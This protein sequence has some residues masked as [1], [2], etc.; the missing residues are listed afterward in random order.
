[1][2]ALRDRLRRAAVTTLMVSHGT[3]M[4]LMGDEVGRSQRGNN[5]AY[6]QDNEISWLDWSTPRDPH[7]TD[8]LRGLVMIRKSRPLL[9]PAKF[10]HGH[11]AGEAG[12]PDVVWLKPDGGRMGGADWGNGA[13]GELG[14]MLSG[15]GERSLLLLFNPAAEEIAFRLPDRGEPVRW[16]ALVDSA[17]AEI[18]PEREAIAAGET[19]P[20]PP[21]AVLVLE[22]L[23]VLK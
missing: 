11:P 17:A 7:F 22:T 1:M 18:A 13:N 23:E 12:F 10:R 14:L 3:P 5:N 6:C 21:R 9:R 19:L 16:R 8:F 15:A 20:V 2:R 4:L